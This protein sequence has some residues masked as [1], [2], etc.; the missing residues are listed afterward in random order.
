MRADAPKVLVLL[1]KLIGFFSS[2]KMIS[3]HVQTNKKNQKIA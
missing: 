1:Q 3:D 2:I